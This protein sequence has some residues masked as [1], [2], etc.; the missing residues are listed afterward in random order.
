M[1]FIEWKFI[2]KSK[3]KTKPIN[4]INNPWQRIS[5]LSR[6]WRTQRNAIRNANC[7]QSWIIKILNASCAVG[8]APGSEPGWGW[9]TMRSD[10]DLIFYWI[11]LNEGEWVYFLIW[12]LKNDLK[13]RNQL[14]SIVRRVFFFGSCLGKKT[15]KWQQKKK[16]AGRRFCCAFS[17]SV[18]HL[19][20]PYHT[21]QITSS[22][23]PAWQSLLF[24]N[25]TTH[26]TTSSQARTPAEF[27]HINKRRKRN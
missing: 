23:S 1:R 27:K 5:R 22:I 8:Q 24:A 9:C 19:F 3:T 12:L 2:I 18:C 13:Q 16:P 10:F 15:N 25:L 7:R 11:E 26:Q 14:G 6:R 21:N 17:F 4:Q 20:F